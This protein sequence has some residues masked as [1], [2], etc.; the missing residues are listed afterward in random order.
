MAHAFAGLADAVASMKRRPRER[1]CICGRMRE[2]HAQY[3]VSNARAMPANR[4]DDAACIMVKVIRA[5]IFSAFVVSHGVG[6]IQTRRCE[7]HRD[8]RDPRSVGRRRSRGTSTSDRPTRERTRCAARRSPSTAATT[9]TRP[10]RRW[11]C[12][13]IRRWPTRSTA[14]ITAPRCSIWRPKAIATAAS[15]IRPPPCW[16]GASPRSKA[17]SRRWR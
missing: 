5:S 13:S 4:V 12:R 7:M 11:R 9:S 2:P 17:A 16:S 15:A 10:P 1:S 8:C 3:L 14:P 6:R